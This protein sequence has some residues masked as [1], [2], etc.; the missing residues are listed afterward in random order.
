MPLAPASPAM[1]ASSSSSF[2]REVKTLSSMLLALKDNIR[3]SAHDTIAYFNANGV[4]VKIISGDNPITVQQIAK[5]CGV[6]GAEAAVSL[7]NVPLEQME[8]YA[9]KYTVFGRVNPDQ[10]E[11]LV[12]A[13]QKQGHKVAMTGDG[14]N[15]ILALRKANSSI[16]FH[17][18][19]DAAKSC[20]DVVL[21]MVLWGF[22]TSRKKRG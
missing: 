14:V 21:M 12:A 6:S 3:P 10:K 8:E 16:S 5:E 4:S 11:A 9:A 7:E 18:A 15:D 19:T 13:L 2:S 22:V 17:N 1:R 20:A